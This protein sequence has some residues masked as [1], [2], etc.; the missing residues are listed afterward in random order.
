[1]ASKR[2][3]GK[4]ALVTGAS[5]GLGTDFAH[6]LAAE[7]ADLIL[8]ARWR[9]LLETV[10]SDIRRDHGVHVDVMAVDLADPGAREKLAAD[11]R[12]EGRPVQVLINNAGFGVFGD[13]RDTEWARMQAMLEVDVMALT[14]L[15]RLFVDDMVAR[16]EG[17]ILLV[18]STG[19]FQPTPTY[20]AYSAAKA[21]VLSF[22]HALHFE[23]RGTGVSCTTVCPGVTATEFLQVSGQRKT[24]YHRLTM[25]DAPS[26]AR[27]G[28]RR[29][30]RRRPEIIPGWINAFMAFTTR[31]TPR[32]MLARIAWLVMRNE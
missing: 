18:A 20:A 6:Q 17:Y 26:V 14:H 29:M 23:L 3:N 7:G 22:G 9:E 13:F 28:L 11:L 19:A 4:T 5:S 27:R 8:V 12:A 21:Y 16:G 25:M 1:M 32:P 15:T 10:A 30:L 2:L 24:W 31:F